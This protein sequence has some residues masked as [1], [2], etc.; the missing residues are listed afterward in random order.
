MW[1]R[2]ITPCQSVDDVMRRWP[3]TIPVFVRYQMACVGCAIG[4]FH[5][6]EEVSAEYGLVAS[7]FVDELRAAAA[8]PQARFR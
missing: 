7:T 8:A 1:Q 5:T 6:I 3:A 4:P 2:E